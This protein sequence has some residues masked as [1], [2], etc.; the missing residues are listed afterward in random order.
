M[1]RMPR[2]PRS[3]PLAGLIPQMRRDSLRI[4]NELRAKNGIRVTV[5][6]RS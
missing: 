6:H 1:N 2:G 4:Y 5:E 3:L